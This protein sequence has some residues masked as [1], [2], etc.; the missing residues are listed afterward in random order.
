MPFFA[1]SSLCSIKALLL[2]KKKSWG[3]GGVVVRANYRPLQGL[4]TWPTHNHPILASIHQI[5]SPLRESSFIKR[6]KTSQ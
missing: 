2:I 6:F 4:L 3:R 5:K 1:R